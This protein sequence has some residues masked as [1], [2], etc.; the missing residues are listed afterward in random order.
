LIPTA[1]IGLALVLGSGCGKRQTVIYD[2]PEVAPSGY[3]EKAWVEPKILT[4]DSL[5]T[6]I[7]ADFVDSFYVDEPPDLT[8]PV[9]P[10]IFIPI[11][12]SDCF[13]TVNLLDDRA[14][15]I[16][17][18]LACKLSYGFYQLTIIESSLDP[19]LSISGAFHVRVEY[20]GF[21]VVEQVTAR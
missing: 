2:Q 5:F 11:R 10:S 13:V 4:T 8:I 3:Y 14:R 6:L 18:L 9:A 17:P 1:L 20:C 21:E 16:R 7:R 15:V 12:Q 19:T